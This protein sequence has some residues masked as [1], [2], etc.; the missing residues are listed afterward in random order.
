[1]TPGIQRIRPLFAA[2]SVALTVFIMTSIASAASGIPTA[3]TGADRSAAVPAL[4][5]IQTNSLFSS[6]FQGDVLV[7]IAIGIFGFIVIDII[8][9]RKKDAQPERLTGVFEPLGFDDPHETID[10][11]AKGLKNLAED[12]K[13]VYKPD[14]LIAVFEALDLDDTPES[15]DERVTR[16]EDL[17]KDE[18]I[19][20]APDRP[21]DRL[22]W[23]QKTAAQFQS[24][25]PEGSV[26]AN[27]LSVIE[28]F[29]GKQSSK[30]DIQKQLEELISHFMGLQKLRQTLGT[31]YG[32]YDK[33]P[34]PN[35]QSEVT[36]RDFED[37][38]YNIREIQKTLDVPGNDYSNL[39]IKYLSTLLDDYEHVVEMY[40]EYYDEQ[41]SEPTYLD[42]DRTRRVAD[43]LDPQ[44]STAT[45]LIEV[46]SGERPYGEIDG[47]LSESVSSLDDYHEME[48]ALAVAEPEDELQRRADALH[49]D[50]AKLNGIVGNIIDDRLDGVM[51][52]IE[53]DPSLID[54]Y[55][56]TRLLSIL[57]DIVG[58]I[59]ARWEEPTDDV[60]SR[61]NTLSENI[62]ALKERYAEGHSRNQYDH[63]IPLH[64][65]SIAETLH[66]YATEAAARGDL[67]SAAAY[68]G[69]GGQVVDAV[70][71]LYRD[72]VYSALLEELST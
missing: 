41:G 54:R 30:Q 3:A 48:G 14:G 60:E 33:H 61:I 11:P 37:L 56:V 68:A 9:D 6:L 62:Q 39:I 35:E 15:F 24:K 50:I 38:L 49:E 7:G 47:V 67:D 51:F 36:A 40:Q 21:I 34:L 28:G 43:E 29:D 66:T 2:F 63:T 4:I 26:A 13:L 44:S 27:L 57:E 5:V 19:V 17:A 59:E 16:L 42:L 12:G 72:G 53:E 58:D 10:E 20:Y 55:E 65:L 46:L 64:F 25:A 8:Y 22:G 23:L 1:M 32:A 71:E 31:Y 52:T 69:A 70:E 45:K 18:K